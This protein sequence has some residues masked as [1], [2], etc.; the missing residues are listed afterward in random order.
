MPGTGSIYEKFESLLEDLGIRIELDIERDAPQ[1]ITRDVQSVAGQKEKRNVEEN[2]PRGRSRRAS[3]N[4]MYDVGEDITRGVERGPR[5]QS[6][7]S[8]P[9]TGASMLIGER[10][11]TRPTTRTTEREPWLEDPTNRSLIATER[12]RLKQLEALED[13]DEV[14]EQ[15]YGGRV[16]DHDGLHAWRQSVTR[17]DVVRGQEYDVDGSNDPPLTKL[18]DHQS[19]QLLVKLPAELLYRSSETQLS[20]DADDY[21]HGHIID[22][23]KRMLRDWN[24]KATSSAITRNALE[25]R[26]TDHDRRVLVSQAFESWYALLL[27]KRR[28]VET[29]R[30]FARLDRRADRARNL[31]LLAKA[32]THWAQ[33]AHDEVQRTSTAQR[34]ILRVRY[35]NA[36]QDVTVV[37]GFKVRRHGLNKFLKLWRRR[38]LE[39]QEEEITAITFYESNLVQKIYWRWFWQFCEKRAPELWAVQTK[40][41]YISRWIDAFRERA[42]K[43]G[44]VEGNLRKRTL[45]QCFGVWRKKLNIFQ[46]HQAQAK[47]FQ[48]KKAISGTMSDWRALTRL[49]PPAVQVSNMV[50]WRVARTAFARWE[51]NTR[52]H[53]HARDVDRLRVMHNAWT[54]WNNALRCLFLATRIDERVQAQTLYK[55]VLAERQALAQRLFDRRLKQRV[56]TTLVRSW[57]SLRTRMEQDGNT[58]SYY[59]N[60]KT[61]SNVWQRWRLQV[62][63]GSQREQLANE[64]FSPSLLSRT[65]QTWSYQAQH[66]QELKKVASLAHYYF[67]ARKTIRRWKEAVASSKREKRREAYAR[68]R[69]RVKLNI[70]TKLFDLWHFRT[71]QIVQMNLQAETQRHN[72]LL[73]I[74]AET[75]K[76]WQTRK[77]EI[78]SQAQEAKIYHDQSTQRQHLH[79]LIQQYHLHQEMEQLA[80]QQDQLHVLGIAAVQLRKFSMR[81]FE[82]NIRIRSA[83]DFFHRHT[84]RTFRNIFRHWRDQTRNVHKDV[85]SSSSS[86]FPASAPSAYPAPP[87]QFTATHRAEAE[88]ETEA[89]SWPAFE[90]DLNLES[91]ISREGETGR[92]RRGGEGQG[93]GRHPHS[94]EPAEA[95]TTTSPRPGYLNTPS[96]RAAHAK[97]LVNLASSS[98]TPI[99]T[100]RLAAP[101]RSMWTRNPRGANSPSYRD[102]SSSSYSAIP[103]RPAAMGRSIF[104]RG[105][106][107]AS[108]YRGEGLGGRGGGVRKQDQEQDHEQNQEKGAGEAAS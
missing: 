78:A 75:L 58:A 20:L 15:T 30:F 108:S 79:I 70:K 107:L 61:M 8:R 73:S 25:T 62:E 60:Q 16:V 18:S 57:S 67:V 104:G 94:T 11:S 13:R 24:R 39:S 12:D 3:F 48:E 21:Y 66:S 1:E 88:A 22:I 99:H 71:A 47:E 93:G 84:R 90:D 2:S 44:W 85:L 63:L 32:F 69:R 103:V 36:W 6:S 19:P 100:P 101:N 43:E 80:L 106:S 96:K 17:E 72:R 89:E 28:Q 7:L 14:P 65:F 64:F 81:I 37:N 68:V 83:D 77:V 56:L 74:E 87:T 35:F 91:F 92:G 34:H 51:L 5:S 29:E 10:V 49:S 95:A 40:R 9:Q 102:Q 46:S 82:H 38:A 41:K 98:T 26:A 45:S 55:W 59:H 4:S 76:I 97:A 105:R 54:A 31:Y 53:L 52:L 86:S 23:T 27:E 50:D 33:V 42:E